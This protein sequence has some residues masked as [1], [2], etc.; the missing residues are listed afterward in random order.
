MYVPWPDKNLRLAGISSWDSNSTKLMELTVLGA[1][2]GKSVVIPT[3]CPVWLCK[4]PLGLCQCRNMW[5]APICFT[6]QR[7]NSYLWIRMSKVPILKGNQQVW[8]QVHGTDGVGSVKWKKCCDPHHLRCRRHAQANL[9]ALAGIWVQFFSVL[10][11]AQ[12][13][14]ATS[15]VAPKNLGRELR[16]FNKS[17]VHYDQSISHTL[18]H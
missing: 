1:R 8:I 15:L 6:F 2:N 17:F 18:H 5:F 3:I 14:L 4:A 13:Q 10:H 7:V 9:A 12:K 11:R 16:K